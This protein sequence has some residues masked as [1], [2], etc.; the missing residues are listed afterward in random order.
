LSMCPAMIATAPTHWIT[1]F[2]KLDT[3]G[4]FCVYMCILY[5]GSDFR[6]TKHKKKRAV[7]ALVLV[8]IQSL[9]HHQCCEIARYNNSLHFTRFDTF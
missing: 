6:S 7:K 1:S 9:V 5:K 2:L 3:I 8:F 4:F